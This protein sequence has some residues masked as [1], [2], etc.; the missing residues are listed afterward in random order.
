MVGC[1]PLAAS[2]RAARSVA[3][4]RGTPAA[5]L[6][7]A[8]PLSPLL[9]GDQLR[10][11][12]CRRIGRNL[13]S[14]TQR[15]DTRIPP[16]RERRGAPSRRPG[17]GP[18]RT[19]R[20]GA[21]GTIRSPRQRL[22]TAQEDALRHR[23]PRARQNLTPSKRDTAVRAPCA[24]SARGG[25]RRHHR[26]SL[27]PGCGAVLDRDVNAAQHIKEAGLAELAAGLAVSACGGDVRPTRKRV[28]GP[29]RSRK[30]R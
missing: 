27:S 3:P 24:G 20:S 11:R 18:R 2:T 22:A 13:G 12:N 26:D 16:C 8:L 1:P 9:I 21:A 6:V 29:R 25:A 23:R 15:P 5:V 10:F 7:P 19:R 4:P 14:N 17:P 28:G 30:P